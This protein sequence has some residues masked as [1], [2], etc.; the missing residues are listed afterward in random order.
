MKLIFARKHLKQ[1]KLEIIAWRN[2]SCLDRTSR[3]IQWTS[4]NTETKD[5]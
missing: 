2:A 5:V 4:N 1:E 3:A